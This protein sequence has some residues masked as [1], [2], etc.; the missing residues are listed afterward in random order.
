MPDISD[1]IGQPSGGEPDS[2]HKKPHK[3]PKYKIVS[4]KV[5]SSCSVIIDVTALLIWLAWYFTGLLGYHVYN[6]PGLWGLEPWEDVSSMV[7]LFEALAVIIFTGFRLFGAVLLSTAAT[8]GILFW[9]ASHSDNGL[10]FGLGGIILLFLLS[11]IAVAAA[12]A[13][14]DV[15]YQKDRQSQERRVKAD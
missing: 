8:A 6:D 5:L 2:P 3:K 1:G 15:Q 11:C 12:V 13:F 4:N 7:I 10:F 9:G 14:M